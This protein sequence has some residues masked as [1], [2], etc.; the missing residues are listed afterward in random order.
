M[1][2]AEKHIGDS[3]PEINTKRI[4]I[5]KKLRFEV[6]KRD[7]FTC[8]YCGSKAPDVILHVDHIDPVANGGGNDLLNLITACEGC[9]LGKGARTLSDRSEIEKQRAQLD[10]LNERR[11][12]LEGMLAWREGLL[13]IDDQVLD[14]A[15]DLWS[16]FFTSQQLTPTGRRDLQKLI[17]KFGLDIVL[18]AI[19]RA[20]RSYVKTDRDGKTTGE[21][22][23][24]AFSKLGGICYYIKNPDKNDDSDIFYVRGILRRRLSYV[25]EGLCVRL[26]KDAKTLNVNMD[27]VKGLAKSVRSWTEFRDAIEDYNLEHANGSD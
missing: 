13:D 15:S 17:D 2:A 6:F 21:S 8:Q 10:E 4:S 9:N 18:D 5:G 16:R 26:L 24:L 1:S 19:T 27:S 7:A 23:N 14:S 25:N 12:Q 3:S 20:G 22:A 11:E